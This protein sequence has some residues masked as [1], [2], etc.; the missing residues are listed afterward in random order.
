M[1]HLGGDPRPAWAS[2]WQPAVPS[3]RGTWADSPLGAGLQRPRGAPLPTSAVARAPNP[4]P[5]A[6]PPGPRRASNPGRVPAAAR[7]VRRC[8]E[9]RPRR[10]PRRGHPGPFPRPRSLNIPGGSRS[11]R[12]CPLQ[13]LAPRPLA[14]P[15]RPSLCG[16]RGSGWS[17]HDRLTEGRAGW[18]ADADTAAGRTRRSAGYACARPAPCVGVGRKRLLPRAAPGGGAAR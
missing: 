2:G 6:L 7:H 10:C 18:A 5:R 17:P 13:G 11:R 8:A 16:A 12:R 9:A 4:P 3:P 1:C 14:R 15:P